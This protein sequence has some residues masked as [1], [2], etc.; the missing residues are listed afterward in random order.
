MTSLSF[1]CHRTALLR[2]AAVYIGTDIRYLVR[3]PNE[4][5]IV[6]R[7]QN[8]GERYDTQFEAGDSVLIHW[9]AENARVLVE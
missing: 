7:M 5:E 9:A 4:H 3:L 6:V 1:G 2:G 8:F